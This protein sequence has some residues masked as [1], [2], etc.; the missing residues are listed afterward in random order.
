M[1][2]A[3]ATALTALL[4]AGGTLT[5]AVSDK[6]P[7]IQHIHSKVLETIHHA[8]NVPGLKS[9]EF[10]VIQEKLPG[11]WNTLAENSVL[12]LQGKD[13]EFRPYFVSIQGIVEHVLALELG[14]N[15]KS[16][17]AV[18]HTSMPALLFVQK[19]RFLKGL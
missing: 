8:T 15:I 7:L 19:E 9:G 14:K 1:S 17:V 6:D 3:G 4:V 11:Y 2:A 5:G 18:I 10:D 12:T 16:L 13:A